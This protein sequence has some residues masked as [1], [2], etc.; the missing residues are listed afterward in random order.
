MDREDNGA[1]ASS[2][3]PRSRAALLMSRLALGV[4][5]LVVLINIPLNTQGTALARSIPDPTSLVIRNGLLVKEAGSPEVWV[6][7]DG[8]FHWITS[9]DAFEYLGYRWAN[10][11]IVEQSFLSQYPKGRPLYVLL[12]CDASPNIYQLD[13]GR[14]RWIVDI[15]TFVAQGYIWDDV[16]MVPCSY[17]YNLPNGDSIPPGHGRPPSGP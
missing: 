1:S 16:K 2:D 9:L 5:V 11:R 8:A 12:K 14:K 17:L 10:V 3:A 4:I 13:Q 7:R 15:P 6:Y